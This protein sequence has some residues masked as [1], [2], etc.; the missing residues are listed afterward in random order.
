MSRTQLLY[1]YQMICSLTLTAPPDVSLN[2]FKRMYSDDHQMSLAESR[3]RMG[4][5]TVRSHVRKGGGG[6]GTL[7]GAMTG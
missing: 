6:A 3:A 7:V 5:C 2:K 4:L 1:I